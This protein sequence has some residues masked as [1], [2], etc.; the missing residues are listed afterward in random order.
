MSS[1]TVKDIL[2]E[3]EEL[4]TEAY[5]NDGVATLNLLNH[6]KYVVK[7]INQRWKK[8]T[9]EINEIGDICDKI[10]EFL[11]DFQKDNSRFDRF[12]GVPHL[13]EFIPSINSVLRDTS[14]LIEKNFFYKHFCGSF[15]NH[16]KQIE[17]GKFH[18][19]VYDVIIALHNLHSIAKTIIADRETSFN[20]TY[21]IAN[22]ETAEGIFF[23][24]LSWDG[25]NTHLDLLQTSDFTFYALPTIKVT[26]NASFFNILTSTSSEVWSKRRS[27]AAFEGNMTDICAICLNQGVP[28]HLLTVLSDCRHI[29]CSEC[30]GLWYENSHDFK[31]PTCRTVSYECIRATGYKNLLA[32]L[33]QE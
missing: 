3:L 29:F 22:K 10:Y 27:L 23:L 8:R 33:P 12:C 13:F 31:C 26:F 14:S 21:G 30:I 19:R 18:L 24:N 16:V 1:S 15:N 2:K 5:N 20:S 28:T 9:I 11:V 17:T 25:D 6:M 7:V 32:M 4:N